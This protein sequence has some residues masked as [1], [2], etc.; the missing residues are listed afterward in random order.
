MVL[1]TPDK[2][3]AAGHAMHNRIEIGS[4]SDARQAAH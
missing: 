1:F 2:L 3:S 4:I